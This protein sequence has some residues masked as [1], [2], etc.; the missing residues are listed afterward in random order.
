MGRVNPEFIG[1]GLLLDV[2]F[3]ASGQMICPCPVLGANEMA[4]I[5]E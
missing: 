1:T 2:T 3:Q 5:W 4:T